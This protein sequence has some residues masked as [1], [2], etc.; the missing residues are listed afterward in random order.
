[1]LQGEASKPS[2]CEQANC[3]KTW[4]STQTH[5]T[6]P[7]NQLSQKTNDQGSQASVLNESQ[8]TIRKLL[9][10]RVTCSSIMQCEQ[11]A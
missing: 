10:K 4:K 3:S 7:E 2:C 8:M 6:P 9:E 11:K 5:S 1:M